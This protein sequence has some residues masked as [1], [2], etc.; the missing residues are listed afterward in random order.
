MLLFDRA[1]MDGVLLG[2]EAL[3][4]LWNGDPAAGSMALGQWVFEAPLSGCGTPVRIVERRG[5]IGDYQL[6]NIMLPD[7][8]I[9]VALA[10]DQPDFD[11]GEIWSGSRADARF[12][13]DA[14]LRLELPR[15]FD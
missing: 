3:A 4:Q 8:G 14:G 5:E 1:L 11:F 9:A 12:A 13:G 7:L 2:D 15:P 6:R 10:T